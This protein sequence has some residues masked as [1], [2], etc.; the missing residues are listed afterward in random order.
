ME[1]LIASLYG[2]HSFFSNHWS[3]PLVPS[4]SEPQLL[5][6][7]LTDVLISAIWK[8]MVFTVLFSSGTFIL[9]PI[10]VMRQKHKKTLFYCLLNSQALK[11][12]ETVNT[13]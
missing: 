10:S 5:L 3:V 1:G 9:K 6:W 4:Y 11:N 8:Q 7:R 13:V 12:L 2:K